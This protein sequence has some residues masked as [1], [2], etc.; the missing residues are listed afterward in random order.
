MVLSKFE[1]EITYENL[2]IFLVKKFNYIENKM[3]K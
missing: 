3:H 2:I 1:W